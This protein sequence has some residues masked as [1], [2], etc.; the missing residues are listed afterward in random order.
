MVIGIVS[1]THD[2]KEKVEKIFKYFEHAGVELVIHLGDLISP[3]VLDWI[4]KNYTKKLILVRGNNDGELL[5]TLKKVE[6]YGYEYHTDPDIITIE[7]KK[8][9]IM[10]KPLYLNEL[11]QSTGVDFILYGHTHKK[12]VRENNGVLIIN[13][14]EACGY[15]T[16]EASFVLLDT[17][18]KKVKIERA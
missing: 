6:N 18:T 2:N 9:A 10:H 5:F 1:D 13:P 17:K 11:S 15:L 12:E 8:I 3:F 16:G 7:G 4:A 14:G